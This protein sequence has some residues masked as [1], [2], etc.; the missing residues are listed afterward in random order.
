[1]TF[2]PYFFRFVPYS[3]MECQGDEGSVEGV[4]KAIADSMK[5]FPSGH[6][7]NSTYAAVFMAVSKS[8]AITTNGWRLAVPTSVL[9][10]YDQIFVWLKAKLLGLE[11]LFLSP[12]LPLTAWNPLILSRI[13]SSQLTT[14]SQDFQEIPC[15]LITRLPTCTYAYTMEI[16]LLTFTERN[17][18]FFFGKFCLA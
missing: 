17:C 7:Q 8:H 10:K 11:D 16:S 2:W 4:P 5:S 13:I 18:L 6:A 14:A 9:L 15:N 1:M 12:G 3:S